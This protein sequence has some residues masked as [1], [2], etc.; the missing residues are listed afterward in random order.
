MKFIYSLRGMI[1]QELALSDK[2]KEF[3]FKIVAY[4]S[5]DYFRLV[6]LREEILRRPLGLHFTGSDLK[7]ERNQVHLG[8]FCEEYP[9]ASLVL[10][11]ISKTQIQF[12]QMCVHPSFRKQGLGAFML[13]SG[14]RIAQALNIH[15][16][17]LHARLEAIPFYRRF[18]YHQEGGIFR[19]VTIPH[20]LM[21]KNLS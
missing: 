11:P 2:K 17:M 9:I 12:R 16:V 20:V 5:E 15:T 21:L 7:A 18:G 10:K 6:V 4:R 8:L 3:V 1:L 19:E 13:L 14:E